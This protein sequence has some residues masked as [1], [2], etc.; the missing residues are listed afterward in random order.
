[1]LEL[2]RSQRQQAAQ[3]DA[4]GRNYLAAELSYTDEEFQAW[5]ASSTVQP[6]L[7]SWYNLCISNRRRYKQALGW[8][9]AID[10]MDSGESG[11]FYDEDGLQ[12]DL[13]LDCLCEGNVAVVECGEESEFVAEDAQTSNWP[14]QKLWSR[15]AWRIVQNN[16]GQGQLFEEAV[17]KHP[18]AAYALAIDVL[19]IAYHSIACRQSDSVWHVIILGA[20]G[21]LD[22][23]PPNMLKE[24]ALDRK[25][26][27]D[28]NEEA[29]QIDT[30]MDDCTESEQDNDSDF[31]LPQTPQ[32]SKKATR[33]LTPSAPR[34]VRP[35]IPSR[36]RT[37]EWLQSLPDLDS[38]FEDMGT[39]NVDRAEDPMMVDEE[40]GEVIK[41]Y[42]RASE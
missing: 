38:G 17:I 19:S 33:V 27:H 8:I 31:E 3:Y 9:D 21:S 12:E 41:G 7:H 14:T 13:L 42:R 5:L 6:H 28:G 36:L 2:R 10:S 4:N 30:E 32:R 35:A 22:S 29:S 11:Y 16:C 15:A 1:M 39:K 20:S 23:S 24:V 34:K 25:D 40:S 18:A 26:D 37:N